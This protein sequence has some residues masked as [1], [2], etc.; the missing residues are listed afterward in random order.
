MSSLLHYVGRRNF[1]RLLRPYGL[2]IPPLK[3]SITVPQRFV[4]MDTK[5]NN[6]SSM[7]NQQSKSKET[8]SNFLKRMPERLVSEGDGLKPTTAARQFDTLGLY[9]RLSKEGFT[10][11][12]SEAIISLLLELLD[13]LFYKEYN[14]IY[15]NDMELENQSHLFH[16]AESEL[17]YAIQNSRDTQLNNQHLQLMKLIRD[18]EALHD[19][20][21]EMS[22]N[23]LQKD[24]KVDFN[25]QK[26]ENTLLQRQIKLELS[27]C[28]NKISTKILGKTRSDIENLRWQTTRSGLLAVLILVFFMVGGASISNRISAEKDKPMQ[29]TLHTV[30]SE[31]HEDSEENDNDNGLDQMLLDDEDLNPDT[32][33]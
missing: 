6:S 25:N 23:C 24:S 31:E 18:L 22:I 12:Q 16:A 30:D 5:A 1:R 19:E 11:N 26:I 28:I 33:R 8:S 9:Q 3:S 2:G 13:D 10:A 20:M 15:L 4:S 27:D 32:R 21:N 17:K 14:H 7:Q 29:V